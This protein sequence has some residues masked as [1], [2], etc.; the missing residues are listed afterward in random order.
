MSKVQYYRSLRPDE[1]SHGGIKG[2]IYK[3]GTT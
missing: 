3:D 2:G 1:K